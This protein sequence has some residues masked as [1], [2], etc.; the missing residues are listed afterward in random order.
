MLWITLIAGFCLLLAGGE[1]LVR[2]AVALAARLGL[3]PLV[4]GLTVVGFGTSTPELVT[5]LQAALGGAPGIAVGNVVGSNVANVLLI[6]GAA[7]LVAPLVVDRVAFG[8]DGPALALAT[9]ACAAV[10]WWGALSRPAG[11]ALVAGLAIY[12]TLAVR[13]GRAEAPAGGAGGEAPGLGLGAALLW[14]LGGIAV[15]VLGAR[16]LVGA[17]V[18]LAARLGV[19]DAVIGLTVVAVGTSLPELVTSVVAARRGQGAVA[20][21]NVIGSNLFNVLGILGVT[22]LVAPIPVPP[23]IAAFDVWVFL[24]SGAALVAVAATGWRVSRAEGAALLSAYAAYVG[25]LAWTAGGAA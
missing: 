22:A 18:E 24:G 5:S 15:T 20:F 23:Q 7:A 17:A 14:T 13:S 9:L 21:G 2:G 25:W 6:L 10:I 4:I 1:G 8:R 16:L 19:S 11:L 3:S 12:L